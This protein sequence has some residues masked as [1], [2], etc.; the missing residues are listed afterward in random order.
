MWL[1]GGMRWPAAGIAGVAFWAAVACWPS[2][3]CDFGMDVDELTRGCAECADASS[4]AVDSSNA[5]SDATSEEA[6]SDASAPCPSAPGPTMIRT[7]SLCIDRTEVT[8]E[9]YAA[10]LESGFRFDGAGTDCNAADSYVPSAGWPATTARSSH[11][12][13][14]V[15]WCAARAFCAWAGK[16]LCGL[17]SPTGAGGPLDVSL[18]GV[19]DVD[20]WTAACS[21]DGTLA[22]PYGTSFSEKAC[23]GDAYGVRDTLPAGSIE[24]CAA[25]NGGPRDLSGNVWE[26]IDACEEGGFCYAHGGAFN[27]PSAELTCASKLRLARKTGLDTVGFRCCAK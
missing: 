7:A 25:P 23:N 5:I 10:F 26:W 18:V 14:R 17:R 24:T 21:S 13:T 12:V 19:H 6:D 16:R 4:D 3:A 22:Y 2:L 9:Q 1:M 8:N 20:E 11:P 15:T 27:A